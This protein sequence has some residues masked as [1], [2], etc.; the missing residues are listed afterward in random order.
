M[1]ATLA[2]S[3]A[4]ASCASTLAPAPH[5]E[6]ASMRS[7]DLTDDHGDVVQL[8][9]YRG[10]PVVLAMFY[11]GCQVRCPRTLQKMQHIE[12]S[13]RGRGV[14]AAYVLITLDPRNDTVERLRDVKRGAGLGEQWH[15]LRATL[16]DTQR[17][18]RELHVN[19]A[20]DDA[21]LDHDVRIVAL[22]R[23]GNIVRNLRGFSFDDGDLIGAL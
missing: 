15:L 21:H 12:A 19:A 18:G 16:S 3:I 17:I 14:R 11:T 13:L 22:D 1:L 8:T 5:V 9:S 23:D 2:L 10:Q 20:Y 4:T 6:Q 7:I